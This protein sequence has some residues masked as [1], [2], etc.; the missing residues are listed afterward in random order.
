MMLFFEL[1]LQEIIVPSGAATRG[2]AGEPPCGR[3]DVILNYIYTNTTKLV[4]HLFY[5]VRL[6]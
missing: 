2:G 6:D 4:L 3:C 5:L 1:I